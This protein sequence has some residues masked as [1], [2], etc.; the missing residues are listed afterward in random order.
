MRRLRA[1]RLP[2][3]R[4]G[5][6]REDGA[7]CCANSDRRAQVAAFTRKRALRPSD[8]AQGFT[9][10]SRTRQK[11]RGQMHTHLLCRVQDAGGPGGS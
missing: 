6:A 7:G 3:G 11:G 2:V 4:K 9:T 5:A 1:E 8:Q 10:R